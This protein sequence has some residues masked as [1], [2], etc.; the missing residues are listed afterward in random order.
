LFEVIEAMR[1]LKDNSEKQA[2]SSQHTALFRKE[3]KKIQVVPALP[4]NLA[5]EI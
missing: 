4:V 3:I 1:A 2:D 5:Y